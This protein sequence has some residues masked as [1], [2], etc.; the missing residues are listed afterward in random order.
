MTTRIIQGFF[1]SGRAKGLTPL[2]QPKPRMQKPGPPTPVF[3]QRAAVAQPHSNKTFPVDPANLGLASGGGRQLPDAVRSKMETAFGADF[4]AVRVH[5]GAQAERIGALAFTTGTDIYFAP[6]RY[7]PDSVHGQQLLG[8]EL[9]HVI[10]QREGRVRVPSAG[11]VMVVQDHALEAEATRLGERAAIQMKASNAMARPGARGASQRQAARTPGRALQAKGGA[12]KL[13]NLAQPR[14]FPGPEVDVQKKIVEELDA[15]AERELSSMLVVFCVG[16]V[17]LPEVLPEDKETLIKAANLIEVPDSSVRNKYSL[18]QDNEKLKKLI[19]RN[20][21]STMITAGQIDYLR[22]SGLTGG[23]WRILVEIHY[24]RDR[25]QGQV[26][27]HKDTLGQTLFVNLNYVNDQEIAGP[28]Y[29]VNPLPVDAHDRNTAGTLP[30]KFRKHITKAQ[31]NLGEPTEIG[32][33]RIPAHG[34]VAFVDELIHHATPL[35]GHRKI[36]AADLAAFLREKFPAQ[37][38]KAVKA[39]DAYQ[40]TSYAWGA[41]ATVGSWL[42]SWVSNSVSDSRKWYQWIAMTKQPKAQYDRPQL[43]KSGLTKQQ[44]DELLA[45]YDPSSDN[46]GRF[47]F[48]RVSIP[49]AGGTAPIR[50]DGRPRLERRMSVN[51]LNKTLP[52]PLVGKRRFFRTW[53]RAV[54]ARIL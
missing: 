44:I 42:G 50:G 6:G 54:P 11:G 16:G 8:H 32:M 34:V 5:V 24:Y 53:V 4:S 20:T 29:V 17:L 7:Q 14:V 48:E 21:I 12:K 51:A 38:D 40:K 1:P 15:I 9:S 33:A 39:Y 41:A 37:Y 47:P 3:A 13:E 35:Y 2:V 18:I 45:K 28:E 10:Q 43:A 19:V 46:P 31:R 27:F 23:D 30:E 36:S 25:F 22:T 52:K 49:K 26:G